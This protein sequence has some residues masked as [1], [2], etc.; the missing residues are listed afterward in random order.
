VGGWGGGEN[1]W[2]HVRLGFIIQDHCC[3]SSGEGEGRVVYY[4]RDKGER[5][6]TKRMELATAG[7]TV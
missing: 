2:L 4:A 6:E 1:P 3:R 5:K 7:D